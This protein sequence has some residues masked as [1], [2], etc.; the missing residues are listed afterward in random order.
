VTFLDRIPSKVNQVACG[1]NFTLVLTQ[2]GTC[3]AFGDNSQG[4]IGTGEASKEPVKLPMWV[5]ALPKSVKIRAGQFA[6]A[7]TV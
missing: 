5:E 1:T 7:L 6:A 3:Y 2:K 4:Q